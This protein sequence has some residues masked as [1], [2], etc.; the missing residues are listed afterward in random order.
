MLFRSDSYFKSLE[1][2]FVVIGVGHMFGENNLL[3]ALAKRG[4]TVKRVE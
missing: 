3:E 1:K 4:I 2:H